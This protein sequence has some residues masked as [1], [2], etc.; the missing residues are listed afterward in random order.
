MTTTTRPPSR[1]P[2]R[3]PG[4]PP[5]GLAARRPAVAPAPRRTPAWASRG[6][7]NLAAT[8]LLAALTLLASMLAIDK[9]L[10]GSDWWLRPILAVAWVVGIGM[11]LRRTR[12]P[13]V[14]VSLLQLVLLAGLLALVFGFGPSDVADQLRIA[15]AH[16]QVSGSPAGVVP[17]VEFVLTAAVGLLAVL[18]DALAARWPALVAVPAVGVLATGATFDPGALPWQALA[19]PGLAYVLMLAAAGRAGRPGE[20]SRLAKQRPSAA[21]RGTVGVIGGVAVVVALVATSSATG[22]PAD[23][24]LE[25]TNVP[26]AGAASP[27]TGL[28]GDLLRGED[29]PLLSFASPLGPRYLRTV[30]L[31]EWTNNEGWSLADDPDRDR[32]EAGDRGGGSGGGTE[33]LVESR[34]LTGRFLPV[35]E[36][37]TEVTAAAR[38]WYLDEQLGSWFRDDVEDVQDY[39]LA[40]DGALPTAEALAADTV[41]PTR[42]EVEVGDLADE[43]RQEALNQTAASETPFAKALALQQWF[44]TPSNGFVYSLRVPEG[45][46]G[47]ALVDFLNFRRGYCEQ[48]AS[49][50]AVMLRAIDIPARVV[51]G[52]GSGTLGADG[53]TTISS[54]NAH[55]WVEVRFDGAGWVRFDPTPGGG[56]QGGQAAPSI[57]GL[58]ADAAPAQPEQREATAADPTA[59]EGAGAGEDAA[60]PT[61]AEPTAAPAQP[62]DRAD[63]GAP[64]TAAPGTSG[65]DGAAV[66]PWSHVGRGELALVVLLLLVT[67]PQAW[68]WAR[69][70]RRTARAATGGP[71]AAEAAWQ[72]IE[73]LALD[74]GVPVSPSATLR[75]AAASIADD[76]RLGHIARERLEALVRETEQGWFSAGAAAAAGPTGASAGTVDPENGARG[77]DLVRAVTDVAL[78]LEHHRP[79]GPWRWWFPPSLRGPNAAPTAAPTVASASPPSRSPEN[80]R[81]GALQD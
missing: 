75:D 48:Y 59:G 65:D 35:L 4:R 81:I 50:M 23:G 9:V 51:V 78:G 13:G 42:D 45:T 3:P 31:T 8:Q 47:D 15:A 22:I 70:R 20:P 62:A 61:P 77:A 44:T 43:V 79:P 63:P 36:G 27:F 34:G 46:S 56:G 2:G 30:A 57:E 40:V 67:G 10:V 28:V 53:V 21:D 14:L 6:S 7:V 18:V 37:T 24:R 16:I 54:H 55:A 38:P 72:E 32:T 73:D 49:A 12:L 25:R 39:V 69:G 19:A 58:P 71:G 11:L 1:N 5:Q 17:A 68:R 52:F 26:G 76:A 29:T 60:E 80:R 74:H 64:G 66:S 41:S 33:V